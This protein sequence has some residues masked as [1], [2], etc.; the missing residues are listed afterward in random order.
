[1]ARTRE[2]LRRLAEQAR[3]ELEGQPQW[4][5]TPPREPT[6]HRER[7]NSQNQSQTDRQS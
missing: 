3:R 1:M 7:L 4:M 6:A 2:T 5:K